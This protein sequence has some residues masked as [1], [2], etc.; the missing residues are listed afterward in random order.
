MSSI[1]ARSASCLPKDPWLFFPSC[2]GVSLCSITQSCPTLCD[3]MDCSPPGSSVHGILQ[4]RI[5]EWIAIS[6]SRGSSRPS[7]H[8]TPLSHFLSNHY[9]FFRGGNFFFLKVTLNHHPPPSFLSIFF[10]ILLHKILSQN[11]NTH[12]TGPYSFSK[13]VPKSLPPSY[14]YRG[15]NIWLFFFFSCY[16]S[17][18]ITTKCF[19]RVLYTLCPLILHFLLIYQPIG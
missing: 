11:F 3:P 13:N 15:K 6:S 7:D 17:L 19:E 14:I 18:T 16:I 12:P 2:L 9:S 4:A 5:L 1:S 8:K 10:W